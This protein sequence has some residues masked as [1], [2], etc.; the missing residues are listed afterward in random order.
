MRLYPYDFFK[1]NVFILFSPPDGG[2]LFSGSKAPAKQRS[3]SGKSDFLR[4]GR[5]QI[6][7]FDGY[8]HS[9]MLHLRTA[10]GK[11]QREKGRAAVLPSFCI[12]Q[13]FLFGIF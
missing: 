5:T 4:L 2:S 6:C 10:Y 11:I 9:V 3:A 7:I 1:R 13:S 12:D 8:I